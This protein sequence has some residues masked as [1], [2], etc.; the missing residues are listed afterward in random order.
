[1]EDDQKYGHLVPGRISASLRNALGLKRYELPLYIYKMRL[2]GYP[3]G[4]LEEARISHS[5][6][7]L[8]DASV[9]ICSFFKLLAKN[10]NYFVIHL[11]LCVNNSH[12][13]KLED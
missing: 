7:R 8:F 9:R 13:L 3:P 10:I 2:L 5:G 1:M 12:V 4:W 6:I 11:T